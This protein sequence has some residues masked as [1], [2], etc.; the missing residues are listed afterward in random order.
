MFEKYENN[1]FYYQSKNS[2]NIS[3]NDILEVFWVTESNLR[4]QWPKKFQ[5]TH[6]NTESHKN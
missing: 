3:D 1:I 6:K 4:N 5:D 2:L